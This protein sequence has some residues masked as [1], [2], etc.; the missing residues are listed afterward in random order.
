MEMQ[1]FK[2]PEYDSNA[3]KRIKLYWGIVPGLNVKIKNLNGQHACVKS[4]FCDIQPD[5]LTIKR[6]FDPSSVQKLGW[7]A[8]FCHVVA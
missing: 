8:E 7:T 1:T 5:R 4:C 2:A 3:I 6:E